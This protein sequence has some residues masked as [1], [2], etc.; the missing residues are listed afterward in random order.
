SG[1]LGASGT[2]LTVTS[3]TLDLG[4]TTQT[5][6]AVTANGTA[7]ITGGTLNGTTLTKTGTS[8]LTLSGVNNFS[9]LTTIGV[10]LAEG[11][12]N[13]LTVSTA[14][15]DGV[16]T[17]AIG[18]DVQIGTGSSV[19]YKSLT[20]GGN[21]QLKFT[22]NLTFSAI[23]IPAGSGR[24]ATV[25]MGGFNLGVAS[26]TDTTSSSGSSFFRNN[27]GTSTLTVNGS[28]S[29]SFKGGFLG[30]GVINLVKDGSSTL[31]LSGANSTAGTL[32]VQGGTLAYGANN[33]QGA[34]AVTVSGGSLE[35]GLFTDSVG[36][37]TLSGGQINRNVAGTNA[38][39]VLTST[40]SFAIQSG[41]A[42]AILAGA[43]VLNKTTSG[44][45]TLSGANTYTGA[46]TVSDGTLSASNIV[47]SA[48]SS[49]L[50]NAASAVT[51]GAA[52]TQGTLSYT[53]N[54]ATYT[55][56]LTIGGA[57]GGRLDVTTSGQ[58]LTVGTGNVTGSGSFTVGGAGNT[59]ITSNLTH[60][61]GLTKVDAGTLTLS[62]TNTYSGATL[63]SGGTLAL[64]A[65]GSINNTSGV[66]LGTVGTFDV[67]AKVGGYTVNNLSGSGT[68]V[69]SL[70]V[71]TQLAIGNSPGTVNF[72]SLTL[73]TGSTY[74][75]ELTGGLNTADLGNVATTFTIASGAILDLEQYLGTYTANDKFTLF[76]YDN[77]D[78]LGGIGTF[79]G[80]T[81]GSTFTDAG[82]I[83]TIN[84]DDTFAGS[85]GGT[86][87]RYVTITAVPEPSAAA[88]ISGLGLLAL[89][90]RRR[91]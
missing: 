52:G 30:T 41:S 65:G 67:S 12:I 71:S 83:W 2:A 1:T 89:L 62:G 22:S 85:N 68:V 35:L 18:G 79:A 47:V 56:G 40:G 20:L 28:T 45:A 3:G 24:F 10:S 21:N 43:V 6:G 38:Q 63:V 82:G 50:G 54:S 60:T 17:Y 55:R 37:V 26:L 48:G 49:N 75:Y 23:N 42:S 87:D 14:G 76:A 29:T 80:L 77:A 44:T 19:G 15:A 72:E 4:S 91:N 84:Y 78:N 31:T 25:E 61:G 27:T 46:T 59:A 70:T 13:N 32:T 11:A 74:L 39:G 73:A 53:G 9:G 58:T 57:G 88:L 5:V 33:V 86:G 69:G 90:R 7:T 66:S 81:D 34:G 8:T 16:T 51:L 36:T 64:V